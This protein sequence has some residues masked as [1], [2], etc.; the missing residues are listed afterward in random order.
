MD[1]IEAYLKKLMRISTIADLLG[2]QHEGVRIRLKRDMIQP[3]TIDGENFFHF[4]T[5]PEK[6]KVKIM[7]KLMESKENSEAGEAKPKPGKSQDKP[8]R[9]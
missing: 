9:K 4:D 6:Y 2:I 7:S 5:L 8:N 1:A 3:V